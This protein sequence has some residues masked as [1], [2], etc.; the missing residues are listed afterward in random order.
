MQKLFLLIF[1]ITI[2]GGGYAIYLGIENEMSFLA[3]MGCIVVSIGMC[4]IGAKNII[5]RESTESYNEYS[6]T[7]TYTGLSA[8]LGGVFWVFSGLAMFI[9][10]LVVIIGQQANL[11]DLILSH[12]G[13]ALFVLG[14]MALSYGGHLFL[15]AREDRAT[16]FAF[17]G[18]LPGRVFALIFIILGVGMLALSAA[19]LIMP[20]VFDSLVANFHTWRQ[21]LPCQMNPVY[22]EQ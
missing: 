19:S 2:F 13:Y 7:A 3:G 20:A 18:S 11:F 14:G 17:L 16:A 8:V 10:G 6:Q 22:C 12:P 5:T 1:L 21:A 4:L 9:I 15:G